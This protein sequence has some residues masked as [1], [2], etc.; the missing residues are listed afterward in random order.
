MS[1]IIELVRSYLVTAPRDGA[2]S[3]VHVSV[4]GWARPLPPTFKSQEEALAVARR[5]IASG[6][7]K[8]ARWGVA[9]S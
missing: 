9:S 8:R 1:H 3:L 2:W 5:M 4:A 6:P 7:F